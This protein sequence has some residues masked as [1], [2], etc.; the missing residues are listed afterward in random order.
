[1]AEGDGNDG[2]GGTG[3]TSASVRPS[4]RKNCDFFDLVDMLDNGGDGCAAGL[5]DSSI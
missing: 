4:A 5:S 2:T 3:G 1:M